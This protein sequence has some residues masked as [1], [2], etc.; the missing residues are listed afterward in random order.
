MGAQTVN[1]ALFNGHNESPRMQPVTCVFAGEHFAVHRSMRLGSD[2][3][4]WQVTHR[5][6][7]FKAGRDFPTR[8][9]AIAHAEWLEKRGKR[10]GVRWESA[11]TKTLQSGE[12]WEAL[13]KSVLRRYK[14]MKKSA[15]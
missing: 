10:L 6:T 9:E 4:T 2:P 11:N 14:A 15:V 12:A 8:R 5:H 13:K 3:R 7:G 1:V